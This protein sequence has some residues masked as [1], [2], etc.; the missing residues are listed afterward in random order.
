VNSLVTG[1]SAGRELTSLYVGVYSGKGAATADADAW[2]AG[3][4]NRGLSWLAR[5]FVEVDETG[6]RVQG[7][8]DSEAR[9]AQSGAERLLLVQADGGQVG[10]APP[11]TLDLYRHRR[12]FGNSTLWT[13]EA[14]RRY[15]MATWWSLRSGA[16]V[17][18][19]AWFE[20][21]HAPMLLHVP[22]RTSI[23]R[24]ELAG[25][26][27]PTHF[28]VHELES[29]SVLGHPLE[30]AAASTPWRARATEG[31]LDFV[32]RCYELDTSLGGDADISDGSDESVH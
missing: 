28:A 31:R 23:I 27:G 7:T 21:E 6:A 32:R 11:A 16:E 10:E 18:F 2:T 8:L 4:F 3:F 26:S 30:R 12:T 17:D 25:G 9:S 15:V 19:E 20:Q 22:G 14:P 13:E 1:A 5:R 29:L 24:Y